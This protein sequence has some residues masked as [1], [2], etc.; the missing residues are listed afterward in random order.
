LYYKRYFVLALKKELAQLKKERA[1]LQSQFALFEKFISMTRSPDEPEVIR[2]ILGELIEISVEMTQAELG[3][4]IL[5]DSDGGI[6]DSI[7]CR[8]QLSPELREELVKSVL[9]KG[10]AGWVFRHGKIGLV[11]DTEN[12]DRWIDFPDQPYTARSA[13]ALP[14]ISGKRQLAILTLMHSEPGHFTEEIVELMKN[15]ANQMAL[16]LENAYLFD[17]LNESYKSLGKAQQDIESYSRA[18]DKELKNCSQI[19][20]DFLPDEIPDVP[21]WDI[22]EFFFPAKRVSG[23]FYDVFKLPGGYIGLVIGDVC[24]KGAGAALFMALTRSLIRIFSGQAQL[25]RT[26]INAESQTVGGTPD[27][28]SARQYTQLEAIRTIALTNDYLAPN[29]EMCMFVTLFFGVLDPETGKLLYINCGHETVFVMDANGIKERLVPTG[30]AVGMIPHATFEYKEIRLN[31]GEILFSFTDGVI[32]ARSTDDERFS[33]K[34]LVSLVSQPV[35]TVFELMQRIG[36]ELFAH[37]GKAPQADD[38]TMLALQRKI[39]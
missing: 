21:G 3:S 13:L 32:D 10:L 12:D 31:S 20:Q 19:Q 15:S 7:L 29:N 30:P 28:G 5:L 33:R 8:N 34:N 38:I 27:P 22:E 36:T 18:L 4:L 11:I 1:A 37:I 14:I 35:G 24:D 26:P 16:V 17:N 25:S 9:N 39:Q 23:D 2:T 6:V